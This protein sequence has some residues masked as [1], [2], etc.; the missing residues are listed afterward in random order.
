M[1]V[2]IITDST[3]YIPEEIREKYNII[4][5]PLSVNFGNQSYEE[6]TE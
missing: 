5:A 2:A 3:S 1:K 6:E 4:V